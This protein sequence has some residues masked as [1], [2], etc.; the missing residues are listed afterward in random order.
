MCSF[1]RLRPLLLLWL[2]PVV[3]AAQP[4]S[5]VG[6]DN[7]EELKY[8]ANIRLNTVS[9]LENVLR[10]A[11]AL[12]RSAE[13][14]DAFS[15]VVFVL[16]GPEARV[17]LRRHYQQHKAVVDLAARLSAFRIV[18]IK[19]CERWMGGEGINRSDLPPFVSTVPLGPAFE[20]QLLQQ[21]NYVYF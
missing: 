5:L 4:I 21:Q 10:R 9:E 12:H 2:L 18:D 8:L 13:H 15:P 16:H 1:R 20:Q 6:D 17:F 3:L 14:Y 19:V 11:E 7:G